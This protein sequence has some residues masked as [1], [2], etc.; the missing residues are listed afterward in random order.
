MKN[1]A[2]SANFRIGLLAIALLSA[3]IVNPQAW[4]Q[5]IVIDEVIHG[6]LLEEAKLESIQ[7]NV[8]RS[9][10]TADEVRGVVKWRQDGNTQ[11]VYTTDG[12]GDPLPNDETEV[13]NETSILEIGLDGQRRYWSNYFD[14]MNSSLLNI[15]RGVA[16]NPQLIWV[17]SNGKTVVDEASDDRY[18]IVTLGGADIRLEVDMQRRVVTRVE[19][20]AF[21]TL[22]STYNVADFVLVGNSYLPTSITTDGDVGDAEPPLVYEYS[23]FVLNPS[24]PDRIFE[25]PQ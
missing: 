16:T 4:A 12:N 1:T 13:V 20:Y 3:M 15:F 10:G 23:N 19:K 11:V 7:F 17:F 24:L 8:V 9:P 18:S 5:K 6:L 2:K 22:K 25:M 21:G 14:P